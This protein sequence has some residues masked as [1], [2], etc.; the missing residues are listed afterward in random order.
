MNEWEM[1]WEWELRRQETAVLPLFPP[2]RIQ[3]KSIRLSSSVHDDD[4]API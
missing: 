2:N 3:K 1:K 4:D